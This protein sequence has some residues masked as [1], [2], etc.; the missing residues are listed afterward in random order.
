MA[1]MSRDRVD[2]MSGVGWSGT[3]ALPPPIT[4]FLK[5]KPTA[6]R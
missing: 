2:F 5:V 1:A 3:D 4:A 6:A